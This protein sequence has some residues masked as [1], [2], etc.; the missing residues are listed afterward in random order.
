MTRL[1]LLTVLLILFMPVSLM[2]QERMSISRINGDFKFDGLDN[3]VYT[4]DIDAD[5]KKSICEVSI[6]SESLNLGYIKI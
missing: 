1:S 2:S 4:L 5:R 3:G 6:S